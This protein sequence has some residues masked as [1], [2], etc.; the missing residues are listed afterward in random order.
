MSTEEK[1][2]YVVVPAKLLTGLGVAAGTAAEML[3]YR[4]GDHTGDDAH[5]DREDAAWHEANQAEADKIL[6]SSSTG[7]VTI[8]RLESR[9]GDETR[10][11]LG[12][13][14]GADK[15]RQEIALADWNAW[16]DEHWE[17]GGGPLL[18]TS[19]KKA[20]AYWEIQREGGEEWFYVETLEIEP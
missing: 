18:D 1:V 2:R 4:A 6:A 10:V 3:R 19:E 8:A 12:D 16:H 15:W 9:R 11:F 7:T 17:L 14:A 20:D 13:S 5:N